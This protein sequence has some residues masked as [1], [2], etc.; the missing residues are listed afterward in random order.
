MKSGLLVGIAEHRENER[1]DTDPPI[2]IPPR[3]SATN[4][5]TKH[6]NDESENGKRDLYEREIFRTFAV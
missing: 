5:G 2:Q 4:I 3:R 6:R 1:A